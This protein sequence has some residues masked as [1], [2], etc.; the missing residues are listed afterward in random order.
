MIT[1]YRKTA[2]IMQTFM[3]YDVS[4]HNVKIIKSVWMS[5]T[6]QSRWSELQQGADKDTIM[7]FSCNHY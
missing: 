5:I 4:E 1:R 2:V 6:L 3:N 7:L